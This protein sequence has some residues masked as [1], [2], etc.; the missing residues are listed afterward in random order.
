M[1][2]IKHKV[3][4]SYAFTGEE[5]KNVRGRLQI[6]A[7]TFNSAGVNYYIN[8]FDTKWREDSKP[9]ECLDIALQEMETS[10]FVLVIMASERRSEGML[11]EIGAAYASGKKIIL[12]LHNSANGKTYLDQLAIKT[13]DWRTNEDLVRIIKELII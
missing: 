6:I 2:A 5:P 10:D 9:K 1:I 4:C 11:V 7:D 12:A 3:F 8:L 13:V